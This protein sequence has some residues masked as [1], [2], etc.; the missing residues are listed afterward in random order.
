M[1]RAE[2]TQ[3]RRDEILGVALECFH[4][5]GYERTTIAIIK[6]RAKVS[7]GSIYHHFSSKEQLFAEL[8]LEGIRE[9][10]AYSLRAL[11]RAKSAEQGVRAVVS[12][13]L[14]WV[15][16][17]PQKASFLLSMRRAEF[18]V[19][20]EAELE[21]LTLDLRK[22]LSEWTDQ[23]VHRGELPP[24]KTDVL[25]ALLVGPSEHFA[26]QW[27]RGKTT[28]SLKVAADSLGEAAWHGLRA[29]ASSAQGERR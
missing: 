2:T 16:R 26:R 25:M 7:T 18:V 23:H 1:S 8:Y 17:E 6:A 5:L 28:T 22:T 4:D 21:A 20:V 11:K 9:T 27:L 12:S 3:T 24:A 13:Y 29:L 15:Q 19:E 10:Q 14:R